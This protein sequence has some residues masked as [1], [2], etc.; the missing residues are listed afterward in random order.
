MDLGWF[1]DQWVFGT[2]IPSYRLDYSVAPAAGGFAIEGRI[3]QSGVPETFTM[4]VPLYADETLLGR[5]TVSGE[6][7]GFRFVVKNKPQQIRV[8]PKG[9]ILTNPLSDSA[10]PQ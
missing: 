9:T 7:G 8:D 3:E 1:F 5:I 6:G 10:A 4:P 2:G